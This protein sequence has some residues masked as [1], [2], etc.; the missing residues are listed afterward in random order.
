MG[1]RKWNRGVAYRMGSSQRRPHARAGS[2]YIL[3]RLRVAL[4][5][6]GHLVEAL[7]PAGYRRRRRSLVASGHERLAAGSA[8]A[9][10][11]F[12]RLGEHLGETVVIECQ[13]CGFRREFPTDEL[14]AIYGRD[15]RMFYLRYEIA[16]CPAGRPFK[17][18]V[19]RYG[20]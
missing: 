8:D 12:D 10:H 5:Q 13:A 4:D 18:C 19:V 3:P 6:N 16:A 1:S 9:P 2:D 17:Q 11:H 15:Y 14:L 7:P 20:S